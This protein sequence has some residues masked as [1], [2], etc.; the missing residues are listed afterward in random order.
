LITLA[1]LAAALTPGNCAPALQDP[2]QTQAQPQ[3]QSQE[4]ESAQPTA[5]VPVRGVVR[6]AATGQPLPRVLVRIEGDAD[7]GAL[8]DGEGRFE[9]P[10]V[11][12]GPQTFRLLKPGF[13]DRPYATEDVAYQSDGPAHSVLVAAQMPELNFHLA[14]TCAIHGHID[15]ST[16]DPAQG[17][18]VV[19]V[20]QVI[21]NGRAV[22]AQ[23]G[24]TRT[25]GDGAYRFASLPHGTYVVYTQPA[26]ES[27][28]AVATVAEGSAANVARG[29]YR[30][31]FYPD[32]RDFSGA[33]RIR[34]AGGDQAQANL[35]LTRETFHTVLATPYFPNGRPF[36]PNSPAETGFDASLSSASIF[37][38]AG[39]RLSYAAQF[40]T[41]SHSIQVSLPD[42][43]YT[44]LVSV[45]TNEPVTETQGKANRKPSSFAGF[46]EFSVAGHAVPNL[47]IPLGL[48]PSWPVRIR[49][50]RT[51]LGARQPAGQGLQS[52]VSVTTTDAGELQ[53]EGSGGQTTAE[54]L[55]P[56][57]LDLSSA[58]FGPVWINTQVNDRSLCVASFTAGGTNLAREPLNLSL[59]TGPPLMDLTLRDDCGTLALEL[60]P[61]LADFVPGEEPFYTVYVVPDFDTTVDIPP[62][63]V[64]PSSGPTLTLDGLT[65]GN[66]HVYV[67][68]APV[69]LEYRN[70]AALAA[71][72]RPGQAVML[73]PGTV[74]NL[75]LGTP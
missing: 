63:N 14:P 45:A 1:L 43:A 44:L 5:F 2:G 31:V 30:G 12:L 16:G 26:L 13:R 71:L 46:V 32:A 22:W 33:A 55:G 65:P 59:A 57:L 74:T 28:L 47:R 58:G 17:I 41:E 73:S 36:V 50:E 3:A 40:D 18:T 42:G 24:T 64:H 20:K 67:F 51:S 6:N 48:N 8:T 11:P 29:G 37:D 75:M 69:R 15:L 53:T 21:R 7:A 72:R 10:A 39:H 54:A 52:M 66:Y 38:G 19:L 35:S 68:N 49:A 60:P 23:N 27:E 34:L 25:N 61:A 4:Q 9:F 62:M 56:D 70:P